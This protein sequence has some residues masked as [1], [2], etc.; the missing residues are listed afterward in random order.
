M[1]ERHW[2]TWWEVQWERDLLYKR[3]AVS[4]NE[5]ERYRD[6]ISGRERERERGIELERDQQ[7]PGFSPPFL[8]GGLP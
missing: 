2:E 4:E 1:N 8:A 6:R 7:S 3:E 5:G